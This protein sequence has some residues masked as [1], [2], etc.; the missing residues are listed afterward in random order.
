MFRS[1]LKAREKA[2][3]A[4]DKVKFNI[5]AFKTEY[6]SREGTTKGNEGEMMWEGEYYEWAKTAKAG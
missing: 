1:F 2:T 4:G 6:K 3:K 5:I